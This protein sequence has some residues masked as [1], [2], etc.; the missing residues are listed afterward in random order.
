MSFR[1]AQAETNVAFH[2]EFSTD[3]VQLGPAQRLVLDN[4]ITNA[5]NGYDAISGQFQAPVSGSYMFVVNFMG[6][7]HTYNYVKILLDG[8]VMD[9][10]FDLFYP[11]SGVCRAIGVWLLS[12]SRA[13][14]IKS[15][16][17]ITFSIFT[18]VW[19]DLHFV[20]FSL[21]S[22]SV[23]EAP[24]S[25]TSLSNSKHLSIVF[26]VYCLTLF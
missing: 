12:L 4:V 20:F 21:C 7:L 13:L 9:Y 17:F 1:S 15:I 2:A 3:P 23:F 10:R 18:L 22:V 11:L 26:K 19:Y 16:F 24:K 6:D 5:G 14:N 8:S 25:I